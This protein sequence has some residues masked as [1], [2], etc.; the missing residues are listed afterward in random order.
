MNKAFRGRK[1]FTEALWEGVL[2]CS[3][4]ITSIVILLIVVFLFSQGGGFF[5]KDKVEEGYVLA[6]IKTNNVKNLSAKQVKDIFDG[7]ITSWR[8]VGASVANDEIEVMD[9]DGIVSYASEE[10]LEDEANIPK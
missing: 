3:G 1:Y 7:N 2:K 8:S 6:V 4:W 10:E 5:S 9:M